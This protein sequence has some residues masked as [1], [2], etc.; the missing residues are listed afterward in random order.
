MLFLCF[1]ASSLATIPCGFGLKLSVTEQYFE[2]KLQ[3][4][5]LVARRVA[6]DAQRRWKHERVDLSFWDPK[7]LLAQV[8]SQIHAGGQYCGGFCV[9]SLLVD[10]LEIAGLMLGFQ[11]EPFNIITFWV[12]GL[13]TLQQESGL[14]WHEAL[15]VLGQMWSSVGYGSHIP[16]GSNYGLKIWHGFHSWAGVILVNDQL[17]KAT[18]ALVWA[19]ESALSGN[20]EPIVEAV[21]TD[22]FEKTCTYTL[23]KEIHQASENE[24]PPKGETFSPEKRLELCAKT[25][26]A[27]TDCTKK[28]EEEVK[29]CKG[30]QPRVFVL[31]GEKKEQKDIPDKYIKQICCEEKKAEALD[32]KEGDNADCFF[33][34]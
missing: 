8:A 5:T 33:F 31:K 22:D 28:N 23:A 11:C 30:G 12:L 6:L 27:Y 7:P 24:L 1:L 18:Q 9:S 4:A 21:R 3:N 25:K 26:Q 29:P 13:L 20:R 2:S 10:F 16:D 19:A 14:A 17:D 34:F 15:L 32:C